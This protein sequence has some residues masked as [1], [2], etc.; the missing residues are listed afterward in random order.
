MNQVGLF[1]E[2]AYARSLA[3][4]SADLGSVAWRVASKKIEGS[5]PAGSSFGPG[6][7]VENDTTP[8]RVFLPEAEL[9]EVSTS[10]PF[11]RHESS[12]A[13]VKPLASE[14][15]DVRAS[16]DSEADTSSKTH[17][18]ASLAPS[19]DGHL[20]RPSTELAAVSSS[21]S[22]TR[23][24]SEP[25]REQAEAV[26]GLNPRSDYNVLESSIPISRPTFQNHQCPT[27]RPGM[28]GFNGAYGFDLSAHRGKLT[29]ASEPAGL[30]PHSSQMLEAIPRVNA[31]FILPATA[32]NQNPPKCPENNP[33][34]RNS[35]SP[36]L[37]SRNEAL[38]NPAISP[39]ARTPWQQG[40][41]PPE[42]TEAVVTT[43]VYKPESV[44]PDL[45]VRFKSPGS[46]S[47]SKVDSAHPDL[48]LQL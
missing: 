37:A 7:V 27:V 21:L 42:K 8:K 38:V 33:S 43:T 13:D 23:Q 3:R 39:H 16:N 47:S 26:E 4:F 11:L 28:N 14:Q 18:E 22:S 5:L 31:N 10:Q 15:K 25:C 24:S 1:L 9:G 35:S 12:A 44:P 2:H 41:S 40:P 20:T 48:V 6:W 19:S 46:P 32:T 30:K 34:T 36:L 45:N 17:D 29:G